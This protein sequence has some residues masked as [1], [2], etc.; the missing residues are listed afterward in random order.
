M[1]NLSKIFILVAF[2]LSCFV[3]NAA[4]VNNGLN[5]KIIGETNPAITGQAVDCHIRI[6][7]FVLG[8][9]MT[10][11]Q[12][13]VFMKAIENQ[14]KDMDQEQLNDFLDAIGLA[15]SLNQLNNMD[16]EPI[17]QLLEKDFNATAAALEGSNDIAATQYKKLQA[18]I[19]EKVITTREVTVTRQSLEAFAEY[20]AFV[21][22][23]S[24]PIWPN[25]L[26]IN[27]TSMRIRTAFANYT[28]D[29]KAALE[30]FQLTWYLIRAAW[31]TG[32]KEQRAAW[33]KEFNKLGIKPGVDVTSSAIKAA[34]STDVYADMLDFAT[35][36]G[37][38]AIEWSTRTKAQIW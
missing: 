22:N 38:E 23:T 13:Q 37:I 5:D 12:K 30:D 14:I 11:A 26:S 9:R 25:E 20:I 7:E 4:D 15:D 32:S 10:V 19:A 24:N 17:R 28:E 35:Q 1:K 8:T 33:Q 31:Q 18:N 2:I 36:S 34:L 29:E 3:V 6:L 16:A 21:A 27:T